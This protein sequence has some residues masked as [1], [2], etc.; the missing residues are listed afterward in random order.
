[1]PEAP[2]L[3]HVRTRGASIAVDA[4]ISNS[5]GFGGMDSVV[6]F[7]AASAPARRRAELSPRLFVSAAVP[8]V[9][10]ESVDAR[11]SLDP[12]RSRRF[13]RVTATS[14]RLAELALEKA[15]L[16]ARDVGVVLGGA[17]GPVERSLTFLDR[18]LSRGLKFAA[19]AEFPH[20]VNSAATGNVSIYLRARGPAVA[21]SA[22]GV[23]GEAAFDVACSLAE[24]GT[25][26]AIVACALELSDPV[27]TELFTKEHASSSPRGQGGAALL[28]ETDG[29]WRRRGGAPLA[30]VERVRAFRGAPSLLEFEFSGDAASSAVVFSEHTDE[31][32]RAV[33]GSSWANAARF[34]QDAHGY[35]EA[36]G[37]SALAHA[38]SLIGAGKRRVLVLGADSALTFAIEL[39]RPEEP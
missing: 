7:E 27:V 31:L 38:V 22:L 10:L 25:T 17:Y 3:A 19:P 9:E 1:N 20:L 15:G 8:F 26:E 29:S 6:L 39:A 4:A 16:R 35:H 21:V 13:D 32:F 11:D 37:A 36:L 34:R 24:L 5:F 23:S 12:E 28:V 14:A 30:R 2:E 18:I 33:E